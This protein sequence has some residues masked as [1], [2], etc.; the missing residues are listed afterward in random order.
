MNIRKLVNIN[1]IESN[2]N[3]IYI[4]TPKHYWK[5]C[6]TFRSYYK[7]IPIF[8]DNRFYTLKDIFNRK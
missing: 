1:Y 7:G 6:S 5:N 4:N 2:S 8:I 3:S